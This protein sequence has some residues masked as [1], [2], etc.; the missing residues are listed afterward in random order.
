LKTSTADGVLA[1]DVELGPNKLGAVLVKSTHH[2]SLRFHRNGTFTY[3]PNEDFI[4]D[5]AFTYK[6][7]DGETKALANATI[8]VLPTCR[9]LPATI[10][11]TNRADRI[12]GTPGADV[13]VGLGGAD[14]IDGLGGDDVICGGSGDD[15]LRGGDGADTLIGGSGAD[16]LYGEA[17]ADTLAGGA[18]FGDLCDGGDGLDQLL[19][20]HGCEHRRNIP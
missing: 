15:V 12:D 19:P 9:G 2:G 7:V 14:R 11:G 4:G 18:G 8:H 5:D 1:N 3:R 17:A 16:R 20:S 6:A 10:I 13:I